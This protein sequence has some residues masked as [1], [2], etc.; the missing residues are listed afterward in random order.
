L[1]LAELL[2]VLLGIVDGWVPTGAGLLKRLTSV[3]HTFLVMNLA[4][5][6]AVAVFFISAQ[7]LWKPTKVSVKS[8]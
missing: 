3:A 4:S 7:R 2:P 8:A 1:V 6:A 5:L